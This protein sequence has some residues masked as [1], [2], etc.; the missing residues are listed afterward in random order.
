MDVELGDIVAAEE[1]GAG[2]GLGFVD[3]GVEPIISGSVKSE[4][5]GIG[6]SSTGGLKSPESVV[7]ALPAWPLCSFRAFKK[8][9]ARASCPFMTD[10]LSVFLFLSS[11][12]SIRRV[13]RSCISCFDF[14]LL[15]THV[16]K[17]RKFSAMVSAS[18]HFRF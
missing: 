5:S 3:A 13:S 14:S 9:E 18:S 2:I 11:D 17:S 15:R 12:S 7:V 1:Q 16:V 6:I 8:R 10:S 4:M